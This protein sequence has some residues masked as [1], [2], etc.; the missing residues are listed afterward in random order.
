MFLVI[1]LQNLNFADIPQESIRLNSEV[2]KIEVG[3][4]IKVHLSGSDE[5]LEAEN[6]IVT[7]SLGVLKVKAESLF[8]P[9]LPDRKLEAI[10]KIGFGI[11]DK[12][13]VEFDETWWD[14]EKLGSGFAFLF[15]DARH[16]N[17][18]FG[19]TEADAE[20]DWTRF[21]LGALKVENRPRFLCFWVAGEG[22][23][24]METLSDDQVAHL[25]FFL[26][27]VNFVKFY[28]NCWGCKAKFYIVS[29]SVF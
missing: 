13:F 22:A 11:V 9:K 15:T 28:W 19:Y 12:I 20:E 16:S 8:E 26:N 24:K 3:D 4:L 21:L 5:T 14:P 18:D 25:V 2:N 1:Y 29:C 6:V 27:L 7:L 17:E 23:K 10:Q